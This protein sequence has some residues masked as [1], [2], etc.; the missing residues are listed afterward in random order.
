[1]IKLIGTILILNVT[2]A[3]G[4]GGL[5]D[6]IKKKVKSD[7]GLIDCK[8]SS[9]TLALISTS[10]F[11]YYP[12]GIF[13]DNKSL[14]KEYPKLFNLKNGFPYLSFDDSYVKF[15]YDDEKERLEIVYAKIHDSEIRLRNGIATGMNRQEVLH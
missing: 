11:L 3:F 7:L 1:V 15:V 13:R 2:L 6:E 9:D 8:M 14:K 12:F 5:S 10:D 4:Q